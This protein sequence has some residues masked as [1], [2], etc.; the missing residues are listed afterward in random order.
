MDL[1]AE[2][3]EVQVQALPFPGSVILDKLISHSVP[4]FFNLQNGD[5]NDSCLISAMLQV[6]S[7]LGRHQK[8]VIFLFVILITEGLLP[9]GPAIR[10]MPAH[11]RCLKG[12]RKEGNEQV[13]GV[14]TT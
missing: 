8:Q 11:W 10:T 5:N 1:R 4:Q 3:S 6:I 2:E 13:L 14:Q 12:V 9:L 7:A